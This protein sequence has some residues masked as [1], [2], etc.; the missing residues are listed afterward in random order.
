MKYIEHN[1]SGNLNYW[2]VVTSWEAFPL[3]KEYNNMPFKENGTCLCL[4]GSRIG[5][6]QKRS[7]HVLIGDSSL[8]LTIANVVSHL[9]QLSWPTLT[10][11]I[12]TALRARVS[13]WNRIK[14]HITHSKHLK[15]EI[16]WTLQGNDNLQPLFV[17]TR[18]VLGM[19]WA[20]HQ[21]IHDQCRDSGCSV[22]RFTG[23]LY[24]SPLAHSHGIVKRVGFH[25]KTT[26]TPPSAAKIY[27]FTPNSL[28]MGCLKSS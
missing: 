5:Q 16:C 7:I 13:W 3:N 27:V 24:N 9:C 17:Q 25:A 18:A 15:R 21:C 22:L 1:T 20:V 10:T 4:I 28:Q 26:L 14:I 12:W 6:S 23:H 8:P 11:T 19:F 2:I